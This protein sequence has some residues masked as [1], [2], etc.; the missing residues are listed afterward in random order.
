MM[1]ITGLTV[2]FSVDDL[3]SS[4]SYHV[5]CSIRSQLSHDN[6]E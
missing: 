5:N 4:A 1:I 6:Y 3:H 2:A